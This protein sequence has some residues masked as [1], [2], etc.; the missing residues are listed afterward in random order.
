MGLCL[1]FPN[2]LHDSQILTIFEYVLHKDIFG[3]PFDSN[4]SF[5][6][7][8]KKASFL[9]LLCVLFTFLPCGLTFGQDVQDRAKNFQWHTSLSLPPSS[10]HEQH[11]GVAGAFSGLNNDAL[12]IAGGANFPIDPPWQGGRKVWWDNIYVLAKQ[13][14]TYKWISQEKNRLAKPAAYGVSLTVAQGVICMG[15]S[16]EEGLLRDIFLLRWDARTSVLSNEQL[17]LLPPSFEITAGVVIDNAVYITGIQEGKNS[18]FR[19][20]L[21]NLLRGNIAW[22]ELP[23]LPG[24]P[25]S[26]MSYAAQN[27]GTTTCFYVFGGRSEQ[28]DVVTLFNDAYA[29]NTLENRWTRLADIVAN[30]YQPPGLMGAPALAYGAG[31]IFLF[32]GDDGAL[33]LQRANLEKNIAVAYSVGKKDSL[34]QEYKKAFVDHPGFNRDILVYNTVTNTYHNVGLMPEDAPV[35]ANALLWDDEVVIVSGEIKPGVRTPVLLRATLLKKQ[36]SFGMVNYTLL[37]VYLLVLVVIGVYFS[38]RQKSTE[39]YFKG[40]GRV[41]WWAAGLS[42]FGTALSAITF[43]AI[44]AK[45]Y[46]TDW[47]YF[48][49]NIS[50]LLATVVVVAIYIP[51]FRRLNVTTAYEYLEKRFN[52]LVRLFGSASFIIFQTGRIA[53]VL[54]LPAIALS[55]VTGIDV[56][57]CIITMGLLSLVYTLIGGIEAVIWTDVI[58]VIVLMGGTF[59]ALFFLLSDTN[60][61]L[62]SLY[63]KAVTDQKFNLVDFTL[64][65]REPTFWVVVVGGFFANLIT[66]SSDQSLVQRYL[67]TKTEKGANKTAWT[68]AWL[69]IPSSL[70][71]F[72]VG[73]ALYLYYSEFPQRLDPF[74]KDH[75]AIFPWYIINELP[76]GMSGLLIAGLF[77]A[78]MSSL[79]SS[80]NSTATAFTTDFYERFKKNTNPKTLLNVA[81]LST[82]VCGVLGTLFAVWMSTSNVI[83]LWDQFSK[84]LGLFTGGLGGLFLL[85]LISKQANGTGAIVGLMVSSIIQYFVASYTDLHL[86][87][88]AAVGLLSCVIIGH[89][90]SLIIPDTTNESGKTLTIYN[91]LYSNKLKE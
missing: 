69:V 40:A 81:R 25:R 84:I 35:T 18:L 63:E 27:N 45:T 74:A 5:M 90:T 85:G 39:D 37:I 60:A 67:T 1:Y 50:V 3:K 38:F 54:Y 17:G 2:G 58:Q 91:K 43:M 59:V 32:G 31:S 57:F 26:L 77:S 36:N 20:P 61:D 52:L 73:T 75:D 30:Q 46:A 68:N 10:L 41:P 14:S 78:A 89:I 82:L 24:P 28:H 12:I 88:Y 71:F 9:R 53:I 6:N 79:S 19:V 4:L 44:P 33:F 23:G 65:L 66:Y 72:G 8:A 16:N 47:S 21:D 22:Q 13:D 64:S 80:M 34:N 83:S 29:F 86:F 49:Y 56:Y 15:G 7:K 42:V 87:L 51:F 48:L 62:V 55:I 11:P 70:L 76:N